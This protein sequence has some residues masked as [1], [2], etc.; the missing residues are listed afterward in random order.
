M[1]IIGKLIQV[2][3]DGSISFGNYELLKKEKAI[4]FEVG[5]NLYDLRTFSEITKLNKDGALL[6]ESIPGTSVHALKVTDKL[7][8]FKVAGT[9]ETQITMELS[10]NTDY[11]LFVEGVKLGKIK[12]SLAGKIIFSVDYCS[13][14]PK[15]VEIKKV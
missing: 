9:A 4:D 2:E 1:A 15:L 11:N 10:P 5:G 12:S 14:D 7:V 3:T 13:K 6:Y 8:Q